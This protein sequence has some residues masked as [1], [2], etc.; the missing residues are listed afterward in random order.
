MWLSLAVLALGATHEARADGGVG[1]K[2]APTAAAKSDDASERFRSG[3]AF[4]KDRDFAAALVEFK[5]A[6]ELAPNY[7][8]LFNLGQTSRELRDY[9]AALATFEQ[10]LREGGSE[11]APARRKDVQASVEELT[12]KV[13]RVRVST[14]VE[15]AE[16][17][18][19]DVPV[20]VAPLAAPITVNVGRRKLA[21]TRSG[22]TPTPRFIDVAGMVEAAVTLELT[23]IDEPRAE[24]APLQP[25]KPG[26]PVVVWVML[27]T[28]AASAVVTGVMGGLALSARG[29]LDKALATF[30]G[31]AASIA[32]AQS[33]T[34]T[35]ALGA[36]VALGL[37]VASAV[38]TAVLFVVAPR[39]SDKEAPAAPKVSFGVSPS[40]L[41]VRG[42][43]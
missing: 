23:R 6:Y 9:A 18:V 13:G 11:I 33:R 28:T 2:G 5:R 15:G 7:R 1:K 3:V 21:A 31:N 42:A 40:G 26:P 32:D 16:I 25:V 14:S 39:G 43:F 17:L 29:G 12:R 27:S 38:T 20:G 10:Y 34:R 37:T 35:F 36:D 24:A 41:V 8:V 4:Y 30:P 19:D 22:Y